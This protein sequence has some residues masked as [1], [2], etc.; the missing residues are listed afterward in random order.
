MAQ[1]IE[2]ISLAGTK[3]QP[4]KDVVY[5]NDYFSIARRIV[6]K[7]IDELSALSKL[8][9]EDL[10]ALLYFGLKVTSANHPF[11][12]KAC[13]EVQDGPGDHVLY[14]W[15]RGHYKSSI[16]TRAETIRKIIRNAEERIAIFSYSQPIAQGFLRSIKEVLERSALL[17]ACYPDILWKNP[18]KEAPKWSESDGLIVKRA[19]H[20]VE[21]TLEAWGLIQGMPT[22]RHFTHIVNDDIETEQTVYSPEVTEKLKYMFELSLNLIS[23][24]GTHVVVGTPYHH[25]G[26]LEYL[27]GKTAPDGKKIYELSLKPATKN[28]LANGTPVLLSRKQLDELKGSPRTFNTQQLLNP[29]PQ[30]TQKLDNRLLKE[31]LPSDIPSNVYK[32]ML[33]DAAGVDHTRE[34]DAWAIGVLG[35]EPFRDDLGASDLYVLDLT[36]QPLGEVEALNEIVRLYCKHG[37]IIKL[38][39]EKV[40]MSSTEIHVANALRAKGRIVSIEAGTLVLLRP[41]GRSKQERVEQN[42]IWPLNNGKI[43]L[44]TAIPEPYRQR[45]RTEMDRW[46]YWHDDGVDILSYGYDLI[47]EYKF[48]RF[49]HEIVVDE[50]RDRWD[51][52]FARSKQRPNGWMTV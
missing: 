22:S 11:I 15:A 2:S 21:S 40:A 20:Y 39:V 49:P 24:R 23:E 36:L 29:T 32:F 52:A 6:A 42:L 19:G 12:V 46:P 17:K 14:I 10:W 50:K 27:R 34:G 4:V 5:E 44:S 35:V 18:G 33:I 9:R 16:I 26:L 7:E 25:L 38:G 47:K 8:F 43:H 48:P 51:R 3:F 37:R 1:E 31:V 28:G 41:A 13:K 45:I 30:G